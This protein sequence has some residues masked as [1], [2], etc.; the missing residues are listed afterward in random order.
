ML[1]V[2]LRYCHVDAYSD[3]CLVE[4]SDAYLNHSHADLLIILPFCV[5]WVVHDNRKCDS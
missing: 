5:T 3:S 4:L 2:L 1:S